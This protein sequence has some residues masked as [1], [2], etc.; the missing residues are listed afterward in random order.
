M[1]RKTPQSSQR[2]SPRHD[3]IVRVGSIAGSGAA[4]PRLFQIGCGLDRPTAYDD[5]RPPHDS[6]RLFRPWG[7]HP[8]AHPDELRLSRARAPAGSDPVGSAD[9][10]TRYIG[11][12][13]RAPRAPSSRRG[14][15]VTR[16]VGTLRRRE[17]AGTSSGGKGRE[18]PSWQALGRRH[19][20]R[21]P[22]ACR[23]PPSSRRASLA[24]AP[25]ASWSSALDGHVAHQERKTPVP[26]PI[27]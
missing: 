13:A 4:G 2:Q 1:N 3:R 23:S 22:P 19:R 27:P 6:P 8:E 10:A 15:A 17:G 24:L 11:H 7:H 5:A 18:G 20:P 21:P 16:D 26:A 14:P 12:A 25:E 9:V